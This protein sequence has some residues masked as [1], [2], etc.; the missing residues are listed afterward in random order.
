LNNNINSWFDTV[1]SKNIIM[2]EYYRPD[3]IGT[4]TDGTNIESN[5][6]AGATYT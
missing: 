2:S 6:F 5:I 3:G 1:N 4:T